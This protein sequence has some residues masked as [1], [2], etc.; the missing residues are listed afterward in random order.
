MSPIPQLHPCK[1]SPHHPHSTST[2]TPTP[3]GTTHQSPLTWLK[4][5]SAWTRVATFETP[6]T[7]SP[8]A[9]SSQYVNGQ[10]PLTRASLKPA[11]ASTNSPVLYTYR[12]LRSATSETGGGISTCHLPLNAMVGEWTSKCPPKEGRILLP[13]GL[14]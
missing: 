14:A 5:S 4:L 7:P 9:S 3:Q 1:K 10:Q 13:N 6:H 11:A 12:K 2:S 8:M